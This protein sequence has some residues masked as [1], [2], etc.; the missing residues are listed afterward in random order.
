MSAPLRCCLCDQIAGDHRGDLLHAHFG[1]PY[2]RRARDVDSHLSLIP[3]LGSLVPGHL[4]LCPHSH[5]RSFAQLR[6][7]D[8]ARADAVLPGLTERL[9]LAADGGVQLFEHGDALASG[10]VSCSVAHAHLHLVP[11]VP[12]LWR[13]ARGTLPWQPLDSLRDLPQMVG[14]SEYLALRGHAGT[15]HVAPAPPDGHPSQIL[16][17]LVAQALGDADG[18]NWRRN[19]RLAATAASWRIVR[20]LAEG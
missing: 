13:L 17:R 12:D 9:A 11:G 14:K 18:W 3:S 6:P 4:L 10:R 5:V 20:Q 7:S 8:L 16:R 2:E 15:W 1:G 19:P